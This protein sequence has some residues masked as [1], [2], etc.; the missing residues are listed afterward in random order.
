[1]DAFFLYVETPDVHTHVALTAVLDPSTMPHGYTFETMR[2]AIANRVHLVPA[3]RKLAVDVPLHV[4]HPVWIDDPHFDI[5]NHVHR[6]AVP[7]PGSEHELAEFTGHIASIQLPRTRPLWE[8]WVIEGL[9]DGRIAI[10]AKIHH[11]AMDGAAA[12]E[13]M[14]IFFDLEADP[15]A[16]DPPPPF[17]PVPAP[18]QW[19]MLGEAGVDRLKSLA[20]I[21]GLLRRTGE[22]IGSIRR[23]RRVGDGPSGGTP[24][25]PPHTAFNGHLTADRSVAFA[26][27]SLDDVK[28][29]KNVHGATVNDVL[30]ATT[31]L[32][33]RR[34]LVAHGAAPEAPLLAAC[35]VSTRSADDELGA[36][37][38][39]IMF[40][41]VHADL[42]DPAEVIEMTKATASATK[43]EH[44]VLG[45]N[46]LGDWAEVA[47]PFASSVVST[48]VTNRGLL[49][50]L[51]RP[52]I[53]M[54]LSNIP[55][56]TFPVYLGGA[57]MERAFPM[58]PV[59]E[60]AGL[61]LTVMSYRGFVD[62]GFL[63][64]TSVLP[65]LWTLAD[66]V[67]AAFAE[68]LADAIAREPAAD[69]SPGPDPQVESPPD[70]AGPPGSDPAGNPP[71]SGD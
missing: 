40:S 70:R 2:D 11:S 20:N 21:P 41:P 43:H 7:S 64:A 16:G 44:E 6:A 9:A 34:Y 15:P 42:D 23:F 17:E 56:P 19:E 31:A 46:T 61:N 5:A 37:R 53:S 25:Q 18:D 50:R 36:N 48:F 14:P 26:R 28:R 29:V 49:G 27:L 45:A 68:L 32:A 58:G 55:G 67:P 8:I 65:D 59:M 69:S 38:V 33:A 3:F 71:E 60:G 66:A 51:P 54:V 22:A 13:L 47:D 1:M 57:R 24:F 39:S 10:C 63:A 4:S 35:P 30:L 62:F 12:A 52:V